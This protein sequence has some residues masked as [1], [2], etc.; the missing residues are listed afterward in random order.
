MEGKEKQQEARENVELRK[1]EEW[2]E[3][4]KK[5]KGRRREGEAGEYEGGRDE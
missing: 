1:E 3:G 5:E 2:R 4:R